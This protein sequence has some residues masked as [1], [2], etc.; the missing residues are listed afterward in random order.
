MK[1]K[2]VLFFALYFI[3]PLVPIFAIYTSNP[4][5]YGT[6]GFVPMVLGA[7]AFTWLNMQLVLSAR[8]KWIESVFGLDR[9]FRFHSLM[10]VI[11][12]LAALIHRQLKE[13]VFP[14]SLKTQIGS[15]ALV[16]L[17]TA[18]VLASV[19][20]IDTLVLNLKPAR[21]IR[22]YGQ[23]ILFG[24]YHA[25]KILHNINIAALVLVFVHVLLSSSA[26]NP[27]V[28]GV[29]I[30]YT[31]A[32]IGFYLYHK[33]IRRY[34]TGKQF[35]VEKITRESGA[36][37]SLT[38]KPKDGELF[39]YLPGQF[40]FIRINSAAVSAEEHPFSITSHPGNRNTLGMTIKSLGDWTQDVQRIK[41]GDTAVIDA[42]YGRF[43]PLLYRSEAGLVL[44]AGG[45]GITPMLSIL[46]HFHQSRP[47]EKIL[48]FWGV[49]HTDE[50]ILEEEFAAFSSDMPHF[51]FV[52]VVS[53]DAQFEGEKGFITG[54]IIGKYLQ[55]NQLDG[56]AA[57]Y[58]LCGPPIMQTLV[59]KTLRDLGVKKTHVHYESFSL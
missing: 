53:G 43:S 35:M 19:F 41:P 48:L 16:I 59:R 26:R 28:K 14:E 4:G 3:S 10:A 56:L 11:A 15:A 54:Q 23:K 57:E 5:Y 8:P 18:A 55:E 47:E 34:L 58:F 6:S 25:Q 20:M 7:T 21:R 31:G 42:P 29:Y 52:P 46:R 30:L 45:V 22:T 24:K 17:I 44:I 40:G 50:L 51:A 1:M 33:V 12:I 9:I 2:K 32:A 27:V 13:M 36:M 39:F 38:L 49:N 37:W